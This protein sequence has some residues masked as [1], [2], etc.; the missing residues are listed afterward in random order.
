MFILK[1]VRT[2]HQCKIK[3][4][5]KWNHGHESKEHLWRHALHSSHPLFLTEVIDHKAF[6]AD[7]NTPNRPWTMRDR[8]KVFFFLE[9][10]VEVGEE[11][12]KNVEKICKWA[13][14]RSI[15]ISNGRL[16]VSTSGGTECKQRS[17]HGLHSAARGQATI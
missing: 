8:H 11:K 12:L 1:T 5:R 2:S 17:C 6:Q 3:H 14:L 15:K 10:M 13:K 9:K 16:A 7:H 4:L